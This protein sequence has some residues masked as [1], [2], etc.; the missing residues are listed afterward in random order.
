MKTNSIHNKFN[1]TS[2]TISGSINMRYHS[3]TPALTQIMLPIIKLG[4]E[5]VGR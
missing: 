3:P 5:K 1:T 2:N 4:K